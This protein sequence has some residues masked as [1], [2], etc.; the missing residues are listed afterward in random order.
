MKSRLRLV[1]GHWCLIGHWGLGIRP[2]GVVIGHL[3]RQETKATPGPL[4]GLPNIRVR[5]D[6]GLVP[7][8]ARAAFAAPAAAAAVPAAARA[9]AAAAAAVAPAA[10]ATAAAAIST[11]PAPAAAAAFLGTGLVDGERA[12]AVLLPVERRDGGLRFLV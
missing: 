12:P 4:R 6:R 2:W 10:P 8:A 5:V 9:A 11:A 1:I 3:P 7:V